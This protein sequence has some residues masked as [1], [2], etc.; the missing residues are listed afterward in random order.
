MKNF[1]LFF[2]PLTIKTI[3]LKYNMCVRANVFF[4]DQKLNVK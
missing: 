1:I 3:F 4:M 2:D